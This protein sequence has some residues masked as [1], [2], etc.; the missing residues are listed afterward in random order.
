MNPPNQKP[1]QPEP[2]KLPRVSKLVLVSHYDLPKAEGIGVGDNVS[3]LAG[4]TGNPL[5]PSWDMVADVRNGVI[6]CCKKG[7]SPPY[8]DVPLSACVFIKYVDPTPHALTMQAEAAAV[9]VK[10]AG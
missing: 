9:P 2:A 3:Y 4:D 5:V 1:A 8:F 7:G 10:K 6:R